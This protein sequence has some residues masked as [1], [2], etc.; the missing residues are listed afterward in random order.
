M[1]QANGVICQDGVVEAEI[2]VIGCVQA[3]VKRW[4][5]VLY[6]TLRRRLGIRGSGNMTRGVNEDMKH[7]LAR[8]KESSVHDHR[9]QA[10]DTNCCVSA[11]GLVILGRTRLRGTTWL[12]LGF[13]VCLLSHI[14]SKWQLLQSQ[15]TKVIAIKGTV[16]SCS[17]LWN[18]QMWF[19]C[20]HD[21][22]HY[23]LIW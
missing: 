13:I 10:W 16:V 15:S 14:W 22:T 23:W 21:H 19:I 20:D 1:R 5:A 4:A 9:E 18:E 2:D 7:D 11:F 3:G 6:V 8:E 12:F 17:F